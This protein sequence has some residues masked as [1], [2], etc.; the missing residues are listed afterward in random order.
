MIFIKKNSINSIVLQCSANIHSCGYM[1]FE[2]IQETTKTKRYYFS[3]NISSN[4]SQYDL[5]ELTE[6]NNGKTATYV[7]SDVVVVPIKLVSGQ[8]T[9][10]VYKSA[11]VPLTINDINM[12]IS[13]TDNHIYST[14]MVVELVKGFSSTNR[15]E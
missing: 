8:Y 6:S 2:F 15:Y 14:K 7:N 12:V 1:F 5:F 3:P 9:F 10:N 4:M 11:S 13:D